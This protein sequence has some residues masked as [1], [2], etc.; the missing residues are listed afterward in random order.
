[1]VKLSA[2]RIIVILLIVVAAVYILIPK[3][4]PLETVGLRAVQGIDANSLDIHRT[5]L[6]WAIQAIALTHDTL[7]T[8]DYEMK[9]IPLLAESWEI[10]PDGFFIDYHLREDVT[11]HCG[12]PFNADAVVYS[13]RRCKKP[14]S[15]HADSVKNVLDAEAL[16]EYT[17][18]I[19]L[20]QW[21]R[22]LY[23]WFATTSGSIVC[24]RCAEEHGLD[25]GEK[26]FCGTGPFKVKE[27]IREDRLTLERNEDYT[28]G[29]EIYQN[30]GPAHLT[31]ITFEVI[32]TD[33]SREDKFKKGETD[34]MIG[35]SPRPAMID[36]L[37]TTENVIFIVNARSSMSYMGFHVGTLSPEIQQGIES[38]RPYPSGA[39]DSPVSDDPEG[40]GLLVRKALLY[41][42]HRENLVL[43]AWENMGKVAYGPLTSMIWGYNPAV[44]DMY[45]YDP[46]MARSLLAQAGY[47]DGLELTLLTTNYEPYTKTAQVLKDQWAKV[48]ITLNIEVRVFDDMEGIIANAQHDLW[49]GGWTWHNA[50]M[51]WWYW[52]TIRVPPASNRFWWGSAYTDAVIEN[53]FHINDDV[54]YYAIQESQRL[55]MEDAAYL[56]VVERPFLLAHWDRVKG[57]T[58]HP[59][60]NFIWKHLDTV[61]EE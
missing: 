51:I 49:I 41:A 30:R 44:E 25:Y 16:D 12:E 4:K 53:T 52:H 13:I 46:E 11:F 15:A 34:M 32:P 54:S 8:F 26:Y 58:L 55:I 29:P 59:L 17:V 21:D 37:N 9:Y 36:Y 48:G 20:K 57:F 14:W 23:D 60:S 27:W 31:E 61:I 5:K 39:K 7:M 43:Y 33:I 10:D 40:K 2:S 42:T 38:G 35:L 22:W 56:P 47:A 1:M 45:P 19:H 28:W 50:D 3:A 18:R 6:D 24:P